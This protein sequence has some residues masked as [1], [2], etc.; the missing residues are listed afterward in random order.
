MAYMANHTFKYINMI[1]LPI[2]SLRITNLKPL[3]TNTF[4][5]DRFITLVIKFTT[6]LHGSN[7]Q[8]FAIATTKNYQNSNSSLN[9]P[10]FLKDGAWPTT[11]HT[12]SSVMAQTAYTLLI[13]TWKSNKLYQYSK[14]E[15]PCIISTN[16]S[17]TSKTESNT[18]MQMCTLRA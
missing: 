6:F 18:F 10:G 9:F 7:T 15:A 11:T 8:S 1:L 2:P 4:L 5:K 16:W 3:P 14:E 17:G 12:F 13:V